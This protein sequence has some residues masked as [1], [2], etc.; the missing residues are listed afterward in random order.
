VQGQMFRV[1][2]FIDREKERR[3]GTKNG[4]DIGSRVLLSRMEMSVDSVTQIKQSKRLNKLKC[5][6]AKH[7]LDNNPCGLWPHSSM[8]CVFGVITYIVSPFPNV[9]CIQ[10][11]EKYGIYIRGNPPCFPTHG[12]RTNMA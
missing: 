8:C 5:K 10:R 4:V 9:L 7:V 6:K 3:I 12:S 1:C 11:H 2:W